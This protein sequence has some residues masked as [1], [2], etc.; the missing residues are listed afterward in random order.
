MKYESVIFDLYGTLVDNRHIPDYERIL[1]EMAE[2]V[3]APSQD[4]VHLWSE[5]FPMRT[6]GV[7]STIE[8][9]I[10]YICELL[11]VPKN[12]RRVAA[13]TQI[14]LEFS[15]GA[16]TPRS[17]AIATL[18]QLREKGYKTGLISNC[19]PDV[20]L[21]WPETPLA[22]LVDVAVFSCVE[23]L[24]KPN[25][26]IYLL[27]CARLAVTPQRCLYVGDGGSYE[28]D[29]ASKVGMHAVLIR[30]PYA[31]IDDPYRQEARDWQGATIATLKDILALIE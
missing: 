26:Q 25:V 8:D 10:N 5:T 27:A 3:S 6:T 30:V 29:A 22:S 31:D 15:R 19:A 16:L 4:F 1:S 7:L 13:A 21:I 12:P 17:D 11:K 14:R 24:K 9:N 28:L 2:L 23:G 18:A 20:P